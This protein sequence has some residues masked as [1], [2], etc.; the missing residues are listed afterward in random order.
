[1]KYRYAT[2]KPK[3]NYVIH[4]NVLQNSSYLRY[5]KELIGRNE[6][7]LPDFTSLDLR[8]NY[9][10]K[11]KKATMTIFVD[12]VNIFNKQIANSESFNAISGQNYYDGLAIFP[13]G[14]MKFEF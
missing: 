9:N 14:G 1:M 2:G 6:L 7:R 13:T 12:I 4:S 10:F 3:E 5:S 8:A 11:F